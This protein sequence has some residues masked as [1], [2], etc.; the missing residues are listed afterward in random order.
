MNKN[1][2]S[3]TLIVLIVVILILILTF[4]HPIGVLK[5]SEF[6]NAKIAK[7][8]ILFVFEIA[9]VCTNVIIIFHFRLLLLFMS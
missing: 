3:I 5:L 1:L 2:L 4:V 6:F 8:N 7:I 9:Y